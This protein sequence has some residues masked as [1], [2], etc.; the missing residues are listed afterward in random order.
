[1][2]FG[3]DFLPPGGGSGELQKFKT[4]KITPYLRTL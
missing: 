4:S 2:K 3:K 1:M